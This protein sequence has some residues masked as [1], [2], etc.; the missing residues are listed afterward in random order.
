LG[1][2]FESRRLKEDFFF[3]RSAHRIIEAKLSYLFQVK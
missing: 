1:D 2:I 3:N